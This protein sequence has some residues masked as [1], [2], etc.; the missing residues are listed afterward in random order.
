MTPRMA[1]QV[2]MGGLLALFVADAHAMAPPIKEIKPEQV[3]DAIQRGVA[4]LKNEQRPDGSWPDSIGYRGGVTALCTLALLNAGV[5][6]DDPHLKKALGH[7][8]KLRS[9]KT[10]VVS[11]Q[12]MVLCQADPKRDLA[13]IDHNVDW[14]QKHQIGNRD[15]RTSRKGAWDYGSPGS[16]DN[17]NSQFALLALHEAERVGVTADART[18]ALAKH[19]WEDCQ[20]P[21]DGSWGYYKG[22]PGTGSMTCAGIASLVITSGKVHDADAKVDRTTGRIN[23]CAAEE[24]GDDRAIQRGLRWLARPDVFSVTHNPGSR[25]WLLYYLY[26]VERVGR[27]TAQRFIGKHDWYRA[28]AHVLVITNPPDVGSGAWRGLGHAENDPHIATSLALL[29]LSKGRRPVLLAKLK[30]GQGNDWNRHRSDV[31]KLTRYVEPRWNLDLTWQVVDLDTATVEDLLQAPVLYYCGSKD[32]RPASE[33]ARKRLGQ[34]LRDYLDRGGFLLAEAVCRSGSDFDQGFRKLIEEHVFPE[35]E[36]KLRLLPPGHPIWRAEERVDPDLALKHELEG[37][38]F[39][40]RTSVVYRPPSPKDDP[41]PS[42][43]CLWEL[44]H[45]GRGQKVPAVAQRQIDAG[46]SLGINVLAY[47]TNRELKPKEESFDRPPE[48]GPSDSMKR[49]K[50]YIASLRHPGGCTAAPRALVNLLEAASQQLKIRANVENRQLNITDEAL[51]SYHLVFVHGRTNFRLTDKERRQLRTFVERGGMVFAD[52][53]CA[54]QA[55]TDAF[56]REMAAIFPKNPIQQ[57]PANDP[58]LSDA[59]GGFDLKTVSRRDPQ[60]AKGSGP[61]RAALRKVP[62]LLKGIKLDDRW[63]V[64]FSPYDISCALEKHDSME[65]QGYTRQDAARIGLNVVVYSLQQ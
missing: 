41:G 30:H 8:R 61:L 64:V 33:E 24:S 2:L 16:G 26:G 42:L 59:Y 31:A 49:G 39:G 52:S 46:V 9:E 44:S 4:Y 45:G 13:L 17:S 12:T 21:D 55:F 48:K 10:Y 38:E 36:Y 3:R 1:S 58:L 22:L 5:E 18:W 25:Q 32:P 40:C 20:N 51:F 29:F 19:Y 65:C 15:G 62:P 27:L 37:I 34:K 28:G 56:L 50:L 14:L 54:S 60:G 43:S 23:C 6:P 47:A 63:A 11:L 7:L 35:P 53:I 57:I